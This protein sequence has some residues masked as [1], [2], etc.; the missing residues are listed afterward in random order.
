[1]NTLILGIGQG[2]M[3][4]TPL[5][6]AQ[7]TALIASK[8]KW[9]RPHLARTI[10]G[11]PPVDLAELQV[12]V[13]ALPLVFGKCTSSSFKCADILAGSPGQRA[14]QRQTQHYGKESMHA[15]IVAWPAGRQNNGHLFRWP[16]K[17]ECREF[18]RTGPR[19]NA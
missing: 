11:Q 12:H 1:M 9:I 5:Q 4:A 15:A 6:L 14:G 13:L 16:H 8:G 19:H 10:E 17:A 3:Q 2:Y 7:A 18:S